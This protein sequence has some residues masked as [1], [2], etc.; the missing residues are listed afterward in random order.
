[1]TYN[2]TDPKPQF[3]AWITQLLRS[4]PTLSL[5]KLQIWLEET[6]NQWHDRNL[7]PET[8]DPQADLTVEDLL[9]ADNQ[10]QSPSTGE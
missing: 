3:C 4:H 6:F 5:T 10:D 1:M 9:P 7:G 8:Y 2:V